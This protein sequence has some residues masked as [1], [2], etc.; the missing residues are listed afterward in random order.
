MSTFENNANNI[1]CDYDKNEFYIENGLAIN[2]K[3]DRKSHSRKAQDQT[4]ERLKKIAETISKLPIKMQ[5]TLAEYTAIQKS[6]KQKNTHT[7]KLFHERNHNGQ[8]ATQ[9]ILCDHFDEQLLDEE[10]ALTEMEN[11]LYD[12]TLHD[13]YERGVS[14]WERYGLTREQYDANREY[15]NNLA[16]LGAFYQELDYASHPDYEIR[17]KAAIKKYEDDFDAQVLKEEEDDKKNNLS[18]EEIEEYDDDDDRE[19]Y[20]EWLES[21]EEEYIEA[22]REAAIEDYIDSI[23]Y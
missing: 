8:S 11:D 17:L 16:K 5:E 2:K 4:D 21:R 18:L 13:K 23:R 10:Y 20:E 14:M 19:T 6:G 7:T 9:K 15:E 12:L 1:S 3:K 22:Q